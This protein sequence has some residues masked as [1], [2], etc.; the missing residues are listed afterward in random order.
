MIPLCMS[1]PEKDIVWMQLVANRINLL[2]NNLA[3]L[4]L[5]IYILHCVLNFFGPGA[6]DLSQVK[7]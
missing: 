5:F 1:F 6:V 2:P 7:S 3:L 4:P